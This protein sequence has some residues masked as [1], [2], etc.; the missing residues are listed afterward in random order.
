MSQAGRIARGSNSHLATLQRALVVTELTRARLNQVSKSAVAS[1]DERT[2]GK[3]LRSVIVKLSRLKVEFKLAA[4]TCIVVLHLVWLY[5]PLVSLIEPPYR[6]LYSHD[7][8][9]T[10]VVSL[11]LCPH[12]FGHQQNNAIHEDPESA[13]FQDD[14][15]PLSSFHEI[16]LKVESYSNGCHNKFSLLLGSLRNV[17]FMKIE[18]SWRNLFC[19]LMK[20]DIRRKFRRKIK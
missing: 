12:Q 14:A 1:K 6:K 18:E 13:Y 8:P 16:P 4:S 7:I 17:S 10:L 20:K 2:N 15:F 9:A 11:R 3:A 19:L 5:R